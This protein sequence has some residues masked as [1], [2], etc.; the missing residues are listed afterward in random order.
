MLPDSPP[1]LN[2][3]EK[4]TC[5]ERPKVNL[6]GASLC[7]TKLSPTNRHDC[8]AKSSLLRKNWGFLKHIHV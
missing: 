3:E 7:P 5:T 4:V 2:L 6:P 8:Y 1:A